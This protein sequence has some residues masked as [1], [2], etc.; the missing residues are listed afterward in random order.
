MSIKRKDAEFNLTFVEA[1][2][3]A[4]SGTY[5]V[6]GSSFRSG[7]YLTTNSFGQ[8]VIREHGELEQTPY[9]I[10]SCQLKRKFRA[11]QVAHQ[12]VIED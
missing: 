9:I 5:Y 7:V 3:L 11:F 8:L 4:C 6:Q 10:T 2:E 12:A 1:M